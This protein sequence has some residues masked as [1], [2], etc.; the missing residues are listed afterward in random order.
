MQ[1]KT[2]ID[3][4]LPKALFK[5]KQDLGDDIVII[6]SKEI[7]NYSGNPGVRM[8][9]VTV[10]HNPK[11]KVKKWIPPRVDENGVE[12]KVKAPKKSFSEIAAAYG[13]PAAQ[14]PRPAPA[15]KKA[16]PRGEESNSFDTMISDILNRKPKELDK[17]KVILDEI[18]SLRAEI[19]QLS[20]KAEKQEKKAATPPRVERPQAPPSLYNEYPEPYASIQE[21]L[22]ESGVQEDLAYALVNQAFLLNEGRR[23]VSGEHVQAQ[24]EK[25]MRAM[26]RTY[27]FKSRRRK[28]KQR[29][30]LLL[31]P[32]GAGKSTAAMKL[33]A[34]PGMYGNQKTTILSTDP[35]GPSEALKAFARMH[36]TDVYEEKD[37]DQTATILEKYKKSDVIIVDTPGKSPFAPNQLEKWEQ[38]IKILKPT[39][40]FLVMSVGADLKDLVLLCANYLLVKPTGII[41]TKFDETTQPGKVFSILDVISLPVVA[42]GDGKRIFVDTQEGKPEYMFNKIFGAKTGEA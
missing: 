9:Q 7:R 14:K 19:K 38:Y 36:E 35:Y 42:F 26:L 32:T 21:Q 23:D 2:F 15:K 29:V 27:N 30:V 8:V 33:A 41:F 3:E 31:G 34:H 4:S 16:A 13:R 11:K 20:Q 40:I 5:A 22:K 6:E 10:G 12:T 28:G 17:E 1:V 18:A 39:D 25:E 37:I 24:I